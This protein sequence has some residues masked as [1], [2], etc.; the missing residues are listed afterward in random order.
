MKDKK[1]KCLTYMEIR[2]ASL[3]L[4][5]NGLPNSRISLMSTVMRIDTSEVIG[6]QSL[7]KMTETT[8]LGPNGRLI[9]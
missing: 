7:M 6:N 3:S 9:H 4:M 1:N 5:E 8:G 2:T